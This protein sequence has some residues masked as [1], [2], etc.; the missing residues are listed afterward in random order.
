MGQNVQLACKLP[1]G[2]K[3]NHSLNTVIVTGSSRGIGKAI[4]SLFALN[5]YNV[6]INYNTSE[7]EAYLLY[8]SLKEKRCS[9]E[10]FKADISKRNEADSMAAYCIKSFGGVDILINNAGIA[11]SKLFIDI[12]EEDWDNMINTNLKGVFNCTQSVIRHMISRK[13]GKIINISSMWGLVGASCEVHYSAAK[14]GIIGFTKALAKELG[15]SNIQ[16]NSIAP[17]VINTDMMKPYSES[18]I[19]VLKEDTPLM[20]LGTPDDIAKC[21]LFLASDSADFITGQIISVNGGFVI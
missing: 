14:A 18:E 3:M 19:E 17:G 10:I 4:A 7:D 15:P 1:G 11:Q 20:R 9:V 13:R 2:Y 12:T 8:N 6:L 5:G 21:A 16:V